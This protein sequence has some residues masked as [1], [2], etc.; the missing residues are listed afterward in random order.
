MLKFRPCDMKPFLCIFSVLQTAAR[1]QLV[2]SGSTIPC[3]G[4]AASILQPSVASPSKVDSPIVTDSFGYSNDGMDE[5]YHGYVL[6]PAAKDSFTIMIFNQT[7][8]S[9][10]LQCMVA[11]F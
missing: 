1:R 5:S 7:T 8:P 9:Y 11:S 4:G 6:Q 2:M 3:G 10:F